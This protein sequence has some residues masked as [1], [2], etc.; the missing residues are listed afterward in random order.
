MERGANVHGKLGKKRMSIST[1]KGDN[2]QNKERYDISSRGGYSVSLARSW[3][4]FM[5]VR[6]AGRLNNQSTNNYD[7]HDHYPTAPRWSPMMTPI[8]PL[9]VVSSTSTSTSTSTTTT[10]LFYL[11][12]PLWTHNH[13]RTFFFPCDKD[14]RRTSDPNLFTFSS[15]ACWGTS[16]V[17]STGFQSFSTKEQAISVPMVGRSLEDCRRASDWTQSSWR[18]SIFWCKHL[19]LQGTKAVAIPATLSCKGGY[20]CY[21]CSSGKHGYQWSCGEEA[22]T[23]FGP[24]CNQCDSRWVEN[25]DRRYTGG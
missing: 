16:L 11:Y 18:K 1:T 17:S 14:R 9:S 4:S 3:G 8:W 20:F 12:L 7:D 25:N 23:M 2:Q 19:E 21:L 24:D 6:V 10:P 15:G 5:V 22:G 13:G